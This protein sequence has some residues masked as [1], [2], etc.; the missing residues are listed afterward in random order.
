GE[1]RA[2]SENPGGWRF[3]SADPVRP[4]VA[5]C[6]PA[7]RVRA[8]DAGNGARFEGSGIRAPASQPRPPAL[9]QA[10]RRTAAPSASCIAPP[11][12]AA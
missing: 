2:R 10:R 9:R 3:R 8:R 7:D 5:G 11:S 12:V 6:F 1:P 4:G